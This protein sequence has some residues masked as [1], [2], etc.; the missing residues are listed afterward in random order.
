MASKPGVRMAALF[1]YAAGTTGILANLF[2]IAFYALQASQPENGTSL[3]R[4]TT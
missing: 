2:L 3:A 4:P 1:A